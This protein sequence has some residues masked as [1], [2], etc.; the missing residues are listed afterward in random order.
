MKELSL[1]DQIEQLHFHL[2]IS[3]E[4]FKMAIEQGYEYDEVREI[5]KEIKLLEDQLTK[6]PNKIN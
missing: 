5:L 4:K 6:L 3:T 1:A 2:R